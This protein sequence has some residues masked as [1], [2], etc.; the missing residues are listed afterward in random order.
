MVFI[1]GAGTAAGAVPHCP[2]LLN[3]PEIIGVF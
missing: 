2:V 1:L 3:F